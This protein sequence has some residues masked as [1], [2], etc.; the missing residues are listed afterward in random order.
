VISGGTNTVHFMTD[1]PYSG[2]GADHYVFEGFEITGGSFRGIFLQG[3]DILIRDVVV[4]DCPAHGILAADQGTG[5]ITLETVEVHHCGNGASQHQIYVTTDEVHYP[6]SVFRM[7]Y[8]Y[9]HDATGGNNVKSRAERNEI[10]YNWIEG[11]YYHELELIGPDPDGLSD[12]P[13]WTPELKREDSD[14]AGNVLRKRRTAA[15]NDSN[16]AI[17]RVGGDATGETYG[18]YRFVNNTIISGTG[19]VFRIFDGI[20]SLEMHNNVF[21]GLGG[22]INLKRTVEAVWK[23]GSEVIAGSNNWVLSGAQNVPA[24]WTGTILGTSPGFARPDS[25]DYR[26]LQT[27]ALVNAGASSTASAP[28]YDFPGPLFPPAFHPP[29]RRLMTTGSAQ[30]R[31]VSGVLDIGAFEYSAGAVER[32]ALSATGAALDFPCP[33]SMHD[34]VVLSIQSRGNAD[35]RISDVSGRRAA[36]LAAGTFDKGS[37]RLT[38][39]APGIPAGLY[40]CCLRY[41]GKVFTKKLVL[42]R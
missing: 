4:H 41:E 23:S 18:R 30:A 1:W 36:A 25:S 38:W 22:S 35:V 7:Q 17:T 29:L 31:P 11:A 8:C 33:F 16:F 28:G 5:D 10:Y 34:A 3:D 24:Q 2:P 40:F 27:S 9:L 39:N 12:L 32:G 14:V 21:Y 15:N 13:E 37:Y 6:G 20:E 42:I 19:A 26:P